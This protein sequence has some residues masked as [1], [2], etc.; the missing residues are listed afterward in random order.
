MSDYDDLGKPELVEMAR[1]RGLTVSGTKEELI[2]RLV[3]SDAAG[4]D[5]QPAADQGASPA[6]GPVEAGELAPDGLV[7]PTRY[8]VTF[9]HAGGAETMT[10]EAHLAYLERA[11]RAAQEAGQTTRGGLYAGTR[12]GYGAD[13]AGA[14]TVTYEISVRRG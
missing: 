3:D 8:R 11:H 4:A 13:A 14:G 6:A 5:Q 7:A 1:S 12:I 10:D 9:P 2:A